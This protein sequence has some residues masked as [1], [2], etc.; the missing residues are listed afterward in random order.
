MVWNRWQIVVLQ[1]GCRIVVYGPWGYSFQSTIPLGVRI[2]IFNTNNKYYDNINRIKVTFAAD[3]NLGYHYDNTLTI[4]T[5]PE[6]TETTP[7]TLLSFVPD[8]IKKLGIDP[9]EDS[10]KNESSKIADEVIQDFFTLENFKKSKF[11]KKK[12]KVCIAKIILGLI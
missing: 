10:F 4:L 6:F 7:G 3:S 5:V 8:G 12:A 2:N 1:W 9:A 11:K